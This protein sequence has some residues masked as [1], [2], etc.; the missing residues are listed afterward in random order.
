MRLPNGDHAIADLA[1]LRD[2]VLNPQHPRGRHKARVFASALNIRQSDAELLRAELL[3]AAAAE[4]ALEGEGDS[5]GRRYIV[6]FQCVRA[7]KKRPCAQPLDNSG[8]RGFSPAGDLFRIMKTD[9]DG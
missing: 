3:R 5:H 8:A 7:E 9:S 4:D 2:Y 1:K 6:D